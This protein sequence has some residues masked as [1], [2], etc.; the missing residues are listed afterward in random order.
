ML[1]ANGLS[2][3]QINGVCRLL[4]GS[5]SSPAKLRGNSDTPSWMWVPSELMDRV[6]KLELLYVSWIHFMYYQ[7]CLVGNSFFSFQVQST[8]LFADL[9][10]NQAS[11][12][13]MK[14][15]W[16]F[17]IQTRKSMKKGDRLLH[18]LGWQKESVCRYHW[19]YQGWWVGWV[20]RIFLK[21]VQH[22][23]AGWWDDNFLH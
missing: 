6:V 3:F 17:W 12:C 4:A 22:S 21:I 18:P 23:P 11:I 1:C 10:L 16:K 2:Y 20:N 5:P 14:S 8:T 13:R 19:N 9:S 7:I 15:S